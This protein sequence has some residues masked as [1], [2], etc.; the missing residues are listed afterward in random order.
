MPGRAGRYAR[1]VTPSDVEGT[2]QKILELLAGDGR[3][4][5][6]PAIDEVGTYEF[7][8]TANDGHDTVSQPVTLI[9]EPDGRLLGM[10]TDG[11]LRRLLERA[12]E[13]RKLTA[14][15]SWSAGPR[16]SAAAR[17]TLPRASATTLATRWN[18]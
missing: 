3:M 18:S 13:P 17:S 5:F 11:D 2:D 15:P 9:V 12:A 8:V 16:S 6:T 10:F 7:I 4:S 14:R 1:R